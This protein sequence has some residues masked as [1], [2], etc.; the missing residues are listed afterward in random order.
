MI[1]VDKN[2]LQKLIEHYGDKQ[3]V[4]AIEEL[5]ELQKELCKHL[6]GKA[7]RENIT[8]EMADVYIMLYQMQYYFFIN[9]E[10]INKIINKKIERTKERL[11]NEVFK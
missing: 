10:E 7:N 1:N 3:V 2:I 6:R 9:D 5:S 4:V 11:L 8:E